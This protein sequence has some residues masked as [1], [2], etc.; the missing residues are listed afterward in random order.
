MIYEFLL[1]GG[2][3]CAVVGLALSVWTLWDEMKKRRDK[4]ENKE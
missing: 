4:R 1:V 2:F 3:A